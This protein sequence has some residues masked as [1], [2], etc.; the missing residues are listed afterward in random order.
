MRPAHSRLVAPEG[1]TDGGRPLHIVSNRGLAGDSSETRGRALAT[2]PRPGPLR[3]IRERPRVTSHAP[4]FP[5]S[6]PT[7]GGVCPATDDLRAGDAGADKHA[8]KEKRMRITELVTDAI[9]LAARLGWRTRLALAVLLIGPLSLT[10]DLEL[11]ALNAAGLVL[12]ALVLRQIIHPT[13]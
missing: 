8:R 3:S 7:V 11:F 6:H 10:G 5:G 9:T 13:A 2:S 12:G 4:P 1:P